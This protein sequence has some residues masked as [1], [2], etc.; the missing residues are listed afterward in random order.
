MQPSVH[1]S[2]HFSLLK[3]LL[4]SAA[5]PDTSY[6]TPECSGCKDKSP[7]HSDFTGSQA[8]PAEP[9]AGCSRPILQNSCGAGRGALS[10]VVV[11]STKEAFGRDQPAASQP[12]PFSWAVFPKPDSSLLSVSHEMQIVLQHGYWVMLLTQYFKWHFYFS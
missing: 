10:A 4:S 6:N 11:R 3:V 1:L 7:S 8:E 9:A 12:L 5:W 2:H